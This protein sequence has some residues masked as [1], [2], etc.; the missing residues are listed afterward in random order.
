MKLTYVAYIPGFFTSVVGLSRSQPL[1]VY[2]DSGC[3]C[4]YQGKPSNAI[5][6]LQY[7]DGHWLIDDEKEQVPPPALLSVYATRYPVPKPSRDDRKPLVVSQQEAHS[8]FGHIS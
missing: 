2:F 5:C 3:D 6:L 4:L 1:G 7:Q 8:L